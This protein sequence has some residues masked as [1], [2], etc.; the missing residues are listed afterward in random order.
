MVDF[1]QSEGAD[2]VAGFWQGLAVGLVLAL[3][4]GLYLFLRGAL[5]GELPA[6]RETLLREL[7]HPLSGLK[8]DNRGERE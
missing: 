7:I 1:I 2:L 4:F 5:R 3:L 8:R 6:W